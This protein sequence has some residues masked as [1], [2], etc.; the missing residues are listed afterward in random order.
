MMSLFLFYLIQ[1]ALYTNVIRYIFSSK[2]RIEIFCL[3]KMGVSQ[4]TKNEVEDTGRE[5]IK[6][7]KCFICCYNQNRLI[8]LLPR[9]CLNIIT[10]MLTYF[11]TLL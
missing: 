5:L 3:L 7:K 8:L 10:I 2:F 11:S 1:N 4:F 6:L 9:I